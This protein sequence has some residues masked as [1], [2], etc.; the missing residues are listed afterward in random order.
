MKKNIIKKLT[1]L[2][3]V[4]MILITGMK[5]VFAQIA[6]SGNLDVKY[7]DGMIELDGGYYQQATRLTINGVEVFC[8]DPRREWADGGSYKAVDPYEN[9]QSIQ[10]D[11]EGNKIDL[12]KE[13]IDLFEKLTHYGFY[14]NQSDKTKVLT[15]ALV[16]DLLY[17]KNITEVGNYSL[18]EY[19]THKKDVLE[20]IRN[21]K[22]TPS[23]SGEVIE[24]KA[25]ETITLTDKNNVLQYLNIPNTQNGFIFKVSENTLTITAPNTEVKN[26]NFEFNSKDNNSNT[27]I[28]LNPGSQT[29][30]YANAVIKFNGKI[31]LSVKE[32]K[33]K[34]TLKKSSKNKELT[35]IAKAGYSL[36][37]AEYGIYKTRVNALEN[38]SI[39]DKLV[40]DENGTSN[41]IKLEKQKY[42][43][44]EIKAPRGFKLDKTIYEVDLTNR[45]SE[46]IL[47]VT[48]EPLFDPLTIMVE[49]QGK[50]AIKLSG[51]EFEVR[52]YIGLHQDVSKQKPVRTWK[53]VTNE[54][55]Q[56]GLLDKYKIDGDELFKDESGRPVGLIGTYE[57]IETKAPKGYKL[58][59]TPKLAYVKENGDVTNP[60]TVYNAPLVTNEV[61]RLIIE[62]RQEGTDE[63]ITTS[64]ASFK[65]LLNGED[66]S[67]HLTGENGKYV[68]DENTNNKAFELVTN[69]ETGTV[70]I[71]KIPTGEIEITE[72]KA[73]TGYFLS[74]ETKKVNIFEKDEKIIFLNE[75]KPEIKTTATENNTENKEVLPLENVEIK[76]TVE[77]KD[78]IRGREYTLKGVL[79]NKETNKALLD[80]NGKE[81][82][83]EKTFKPE[84]E[85]GIVELIF[86]INANILKGK[87]IVVFENLYRENKEVATHTD[88]NDKDQTVKFTNPEI[89]TTFFEVDT[90]QKEF[91]AVGKVNLVDVVTYKNL[92]KD[93]NYM[94]NLV[95]MDK[96]TNKALL[97]E[98]GS[99]I[100]QNI[101]FNAK[102]TTGKVE[103]PVTIDL[104]KLKGKE[105][106]AFETLSYNGEIIARHEDINDKDQTIRVTEPKIKTTLIEKGTNN[107]EVHAEK[108]TLIDK[109]KYS[110]VIIGKKYTLDGEIVRKDTKEVL[111]TS[112]ITFVAK[113]SSGVIDLEFEVDA[114][115]LEGKE[116]VAF[117]TLS[118]EGVEL[119]VHADINDKDQT[120]IVKTPNNP[121]TGDMG[122]FAVISTLV[123]S[124]VAL[125]FVTKKQRQINR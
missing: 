72:T 60:G 88:I 49:K 124:V 110:N 26:T 38:K 105:I 15:Q 99:K 116:I 102:E 108:V 27:T 37:G 29:T 125:Y 95:L 107:K 113:S 79:M 85:N 43:V 23:F 114:S 118:R 24:L 17:D 58:D 19:N 45:D 28:F 76:D 94:L 119:S 14:T 65:V 97:D 89:K 2:T 77:Y 83:V 86:S 5:E 57:F 42:F 35:D 68:Y 109:V 50:E 20:K 96:Q 101:E 40:T 48:D 53:F 54:N 78:L 75:K 122:I 106:V 111:A 91:N 62:K 11:R 1:S 64:Q 61:K 74:K 41:T 103:V 33:Q 115:K 34:L 123:I 84:S 32:E 44:K 92:V 67:K 70:E 93:K 98:K 90:K 69:F 18:S 47:N 13:K 104:S 120:I 21:H 82:I 7:L 87:E 121:N 30:A 112:S 63:L 46:Y 117:E 8:I 66:I 12:T 4:I 16:F 71:E 100:I 6:P 22:T 3:L 39:M 73:P 59:S 9:V 55:G 25:N 10:I 31:S 81:I 80:E 51:A 52:Y 36:L 56:F